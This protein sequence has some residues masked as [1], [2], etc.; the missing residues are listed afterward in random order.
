MSEKRLRVPD[1]LRDLLTD[2][3]EENPLASEKELKRLFVSAIRGNADL[4]NAAIEWILR[5]D[6][7]L[8]Y[9]GG[10]DFVRKN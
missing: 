5:T 4:E 9:I 6:P 1:L 3:R 7:G 10:R 2:L 8:V